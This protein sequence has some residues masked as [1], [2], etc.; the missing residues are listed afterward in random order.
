ML[1]VRP[2]KGWGDTMLYSDNLQKI[3]ERM[4][5]AAI[6]R[7]VSLQD[8]T[9]VAISKNVT[10]ESI[11]NAIKLGISDFGENRVQEA[12]PKIET[13]PACIRWH[14]VGHLQT[15][16]VKF[17]LPAF[18]LVHSLDSLR[19]ARAL[20]D[21]GAKK[22]REVNVLLQVNVAN[23]KSKFGFRLEE[24]R[25]ALEEVAGYSHLKVKGL[26]TIAPFVSN[27]EEVRPFFRAL[28]HLYNDV[29]IPGI[30][31]KHLSMGMTNDYEIAI[32]EG[33]NMIRLG[34]AFFGEREQ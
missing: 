10:A 13:L 28:Y 14:F 25:E 4:Q 6:K 8:I 34:T 12:L 3:Q 32:E 9:F 11:H 31:M 20:Q 18:S 33:S 21:E 22:G 15:N 7:G 24:V 1:V 17:V 30:E 5:S 19:L 2:A 27:P 29:K 26:M 16:K 23:E